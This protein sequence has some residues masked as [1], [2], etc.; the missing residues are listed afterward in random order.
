MINSRYQNQDEIYNVTG[1]IKHL[2]MLYK[3]AVKRVKPKSSHGKKNNFFSLILY[4]YEMM[5]VHQAY[6]DI[7]FLRY[8]D[9][10]L[11]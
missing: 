6:N 1:R 8:V 2:C 10:S 11:C 7:P 9:K 5:D 4:L 3:K